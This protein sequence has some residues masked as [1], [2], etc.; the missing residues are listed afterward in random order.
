MTF[1][2]FGVGDATDKVSRPPVSWVRYHGFT[3]HEAPATHT[4][5]AAVRTWL[6]E[7]TWQE[8]PENV[9]EWFGVASLQG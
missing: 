5:V 6:Q 8:G 9:L 2:P 4:V 7:E 3:S 1:L